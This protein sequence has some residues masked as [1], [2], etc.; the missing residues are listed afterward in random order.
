[1]TILFLPATPF[2]SSTMSTSLPSVTV[3][4][5]LHSEH[6]SSSS[7]PY[8]KLIENAVDVEEIDINLYKSRQLWTPIGARGV[9][10]GQVVAQALRA[11][12]KTVNPEFRIH[13]N[14]FHLKFIG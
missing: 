8:A 11:A 5:E 4:S 3:F 6:P 14:I 1:M 7:A 9:F 10:G 2:L 13:V 12:T